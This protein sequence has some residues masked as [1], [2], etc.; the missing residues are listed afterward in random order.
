[1]GFQTPMTL[2]NFR[3]YVRQMTLQ[4]YFLEILERSIFLEDLNLM[5]LLEG[6]PPASDPLVLAML[7]TC[8]LTRLAFGLTKHV[9]E[10]ISLSDAVSPFKHQNLQSVFQALVC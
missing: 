2:G 10:Y 6:R 7:G 3:C 1:M 8:T 4:V 5:L 9:I